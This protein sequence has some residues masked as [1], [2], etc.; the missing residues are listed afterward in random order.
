MRIKLWGVRGSLPSPLT[1]EAI[2]ERVRG[3]FEEFFKRGFKKPQQVDDFLHSLEPYKYGGYGGNTPCIEVR[4]EEAQMIIDGGSGLR[5]LGYEMMKGLCGR[6][7][8]EAHIFFTH[9]HW[10]HLMG[11]PFFTPIFVPGNTIHVYSVQPELQEVFQTVF[12]KPYFPVSF[13]QVGAKIVFHRLEPRKPFEHRDLTITPYEL[14]HPDPCWGYRIEH[15]GKVLAHCVDT[16]ATRVSRKEMGK[17][18]PL[19]QN[20]DLMVFDAQYTLMEAVERINWGHSVASVGLDIA[21]REGIKRVVFMHH[22]PASS[23]WRIQEA[24]IEAANYLQ[25]QLKREKRGAPVQNEVL[26]EFAREG[27]EIEL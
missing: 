23:D 16:E 20:V 8:G 26:W 1:P 7:A 13:D 12:K 9:F 6:G 2:E 18:L 27:M 25:N 17:D 5:M 24:E 14:D 19:Y 11:L 10:D 21:R 15:E 22:D 4:S 3:L